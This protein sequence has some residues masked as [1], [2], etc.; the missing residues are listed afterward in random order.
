M[1]KISRSIIN[2]FKQ[3]YYLLTPLLMFLSYPSLDL[4]GFR[5]CALLAWFAF[6]PL[7]VFVRKKTLLRVY[8]YSFAMGLIGNYLCYRWIGD[9]GEF[10]EYGPAFIRVLLIPYLSMFLGLKIFIGEALSRRH[11]RLR[12]LIY[13]SAWIFVDWIQSI[14]FLAFPWPY[15][16]YTQY[17]FG[18]IVQAAS[19]IGVLGVSFMIVLVNR[20]AADLILSCGGKR[21]IAGMVRTPESR[22]LAFAAGVVF[23]SILYGV[24]V[25][26]TAKEPVKRDLRVSA[27]QSCISP[28]ENWSSNRFRYLAELKRFTD[29]ALADGPDLVVWSE[30]ATLET[31]SYDYEKGDLNMFERDLLDYVRRADRPLVTGEIGMI[32]D[33]S[34]DYTR[35]YPLNSAAYINNY[36]EVIGSYA[37]INLVPFGE[38]FP[39]EKWFPF[40][41]DITREFGGSDFVPGDRPVLFDHAGNSFGILICYEGIFH[42]LCREYRNLGADFF[43]NI[44]N[45][46]WTDS[47]AGHM[48]HF[49]ASIFRAVENGVWYVRAGNDGFT[50]LIDPYGRIRSSMPI[51][52]QGHVTGDIDFSLNRDTFY[53]RCGDLVLYAAQALLA[54]AVAVWLFGWIRKALS[55]RA[56]G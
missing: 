8:L 38:W 27:V 31:I 48:Q 16:A 35:R 53:T 28:W 42:R 43:I 11:E 51:L 37:K 6:V 22:R 20:T 45:D 14:G 32:E 1:N 21:P 46:G 13:P 47:Y 33:T 26:M 55:K 49:S 50:A 39:Y 5:G 9:F 15:L 56:E 52:M 25:L 18:P 2:A 36:G 44:T 10:V 41:K 3:D 7:F 4:P 17:R 24:L 12:F 19:I 34:G 54:W 30:S 40:V 29:E 23:V